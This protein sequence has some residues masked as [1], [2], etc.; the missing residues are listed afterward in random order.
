MGSSPKPP[1][2]A[3]LRREVKNLDQALTTL[4]ETRRKM[5]TPLRSSSAQL[6]ER[7]DRLRV[8][9]GETETKLLERKA[10]AER[11]LRDLGG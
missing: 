1:T 2:A 8:K 10:E 3:S 11:K 6:N 9:L 5:A 4:K 7:Y